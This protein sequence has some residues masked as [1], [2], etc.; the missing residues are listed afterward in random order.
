MQQRHNFKISKSFSVNA[1]TIYNVWLDSTKH[2]AMT[3]E[4]ANFSQQEGDT[5]T[6]WDGY[7]TGQNIKLVP[8]S[9]YYSILAYC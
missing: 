9:N 2:T 1:E 7:I 3:G 8:H 4:K 5:F 6:A